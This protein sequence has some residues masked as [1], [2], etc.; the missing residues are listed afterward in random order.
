LIALLATF[1][2]AGVFLPVILPSRCEIGTS[3][4][5]AA[6]RATEEKREK[7]KE[8]KEEGLKITVWA[9]ATLLYNIEEIS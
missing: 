8:L 3:L 7:K 4:R 2:L 6:Q 9:C 1:V 5:S